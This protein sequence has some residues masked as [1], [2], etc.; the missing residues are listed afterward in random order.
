MTTQFMIFFLHTSHGDSEGFYSAAMDKGC[1]RVIL[2][3][4]KVLVKEME[5]GLHFFGSQLPLHQL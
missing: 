5:V 2:I 3:H 1:R 4:T